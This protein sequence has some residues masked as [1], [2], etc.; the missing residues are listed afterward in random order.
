MIDYSWHFTILQKEEISQL[1]RDLKFQLIIRHL[2]SERSQKESI[3]IIHADNDIVQICC[4]IEGH[5]LQS[6]KQNFIQIHTLFH[7]F[8]YDNRSSLK[9]KFSFFEFHKFHHIHQL[10]VFFVNLINNILQLENLKRIEKWLTF[11][12]R[13]KF[14]NCKKF[15]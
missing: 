8:A 7:S 4:K 2:A 6:T 1:R 12:I 14:S 15:C 9:I 11:P 3:L 5:E 10:H 13:F